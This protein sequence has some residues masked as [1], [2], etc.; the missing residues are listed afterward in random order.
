MQIHL[1]K[2]DLKDLQTGWRGWIDRAARLT[3]AA[4]FLLA[5]V[6][7]LL[8]PADFGQVIS[9]YGIVPDGLVLETAVLLI[10]VELITAVGLLLGRFWAVISAAGML[11]LFIAV[12]GYGMYLGL[13]IDCGCFGPED[14]E[15]GAVSSLRTSFVR[16]LALL[17]PVIYLLATSTK[18]SASLSTVNLR[19]TTE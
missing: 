8:N 14:P 15:H 18:K 10:A 7:K 2:S 12:L 19:K 9:M 13:D 4:V 6:P 5:A 16:D 3:L 11:L 17:I 1:R